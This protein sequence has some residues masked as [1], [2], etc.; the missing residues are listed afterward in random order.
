MS[1]SELER[2]T[3]DLQ[4]N[5]GLREEMRRAPDAAKAASVAE[6][7]GYAI[8]ADEIAAAA[9]SLSD[10][11]LGGVSGGLTDDPRRGIPGGIFGPPKR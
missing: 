9:K 11:A 1:A 3:R 6:R 10:D 5:A 2:L 4:S 7:H 8:T